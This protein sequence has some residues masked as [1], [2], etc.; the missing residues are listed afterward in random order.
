MNKL[1]IAVVGRGNVGTHLFKALQR[2]AEVVSVNSRTLEGMPEDSDLAIICVK[3]EA[4]GEI[5]ERLAG[6]AKTIV[7]TA[8]SVPMEILSGHAPN[9]GVLYPLQTF[10][11]EKSL[12]YH[13]IPVFIEGINNETISLLDATARLF[14]DKVK[15]C[16]SEKRKWLHL[17]SVFACNFTNALFDVSSGIMEEN[18]LDF[19]DLLPLINETLD[20]LNYM[21]PH[22][23]QTGPA[24]RNDQ[25]VMAG[26][27][28][29]LE[30]KPTESEL[31][32]LISSLII[33]RNESFKNN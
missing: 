29:M 30:G 13:E 15:L 22:A 33:Q 26:H 2:K 17:S 18:G 1:K 14:S 12:E 4:V 5:A 16:S 28:K 23:A 20:K 9:I 10:T 3:D 19:K 21:E 27:L 24:V 11:K 32:Q 25:T 8:G 6:K 7:H 31:Y